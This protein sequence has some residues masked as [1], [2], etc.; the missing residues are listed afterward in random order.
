MKKNFLNGAIKAIAITAFAAVIGFAVSSC[1]D[2][3]G[4]LGS[5]GS[6]SYADLYG[7]W[8]NNTLSTSSVVIASG[9]IT[10]RTTTG[11]NT[12]YEIISFTKVSGSVPFMNGFNF[13]TEATS[14]GA[15]KK[16]FRIMLNTDKKSIRIGADIGGNVYN[17]EQPA[18]VTCDVCKNGCPE[19]N[20]CTCTASAICNDCKNE[21]VCLRIF[22]TWEHP[23]SATDG[24]NG[25][26]TLTISKTE[27]K[28]T[29][30][31]GYPITYSNLTWGQEVANPISNATI[32]A[33][34]PTGYMITGTR[35]STAYTTE[36]KFLAI[37]AN[38][39]Q[40]FIWAVDPADTDP[41]Y[42]TPHTFTRKD[43]LGM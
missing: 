27:I 24:K 21:C 26:Y 2:P 23:Y 9:T 22:G 30:K 25:P 28:R 42:L 37:S 8:T 32:K 33:Q 15:I 14:D 20:G 10:E 6:G 35:T 43:L 18:A 19:P 40:L 41:H 31:D 38:M 12:R 36:F 13:K 17:K 4:L 16:D 3:E 39:S 7:T 29:D 1:E 11:T 5:G 34:F